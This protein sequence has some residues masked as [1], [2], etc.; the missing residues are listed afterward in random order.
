MANPH[1]TRLLGILRER[2]GELRKMAGSQSLFS[3]GDDAAVIYVRYSKIHDAGRSFFGLRQSDLRQLEGRNSFLCLLLDDGSQP[4]LI[5]YADFEE[6]FHNAS[7]ASDGQYKV[8]LL[9]YDEGRELY[10]SRQGRFNV[11]GYVGLDA[12][13][14]SLDANRLRRTY[15]LSHSQVQTLLAGIGS[16]KGY[17][18]WVPA[19][20]V[21]QMDWSLTEPFALRRAIP[22]GYE[23]INSILSEIDVMWVRQGQNS[24][25]GLF[26]VEHSTPI[27]SGLLR[28]NDVLLTDQSLN[29]FSIVSN[30]TRRSVFSRQAF[31]PTFRRSGLAE[32]V[33][34]LEYPNVAEWHARLARGERDETAIQDEP[35]LRRG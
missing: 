9:T 22:D 33:S 1:K 28:F 4:L 5:P 14:R 30:N 32:L 16:L 3:L 12:V 25:E 10:I 35:S 27:Y 21:A 24:I 34:F 23:S 7:P 29:R 13:I 11:E 8:Q 19:C 6:I 31:R 20:D 18:V 15:D 26:E 2:F 17:E